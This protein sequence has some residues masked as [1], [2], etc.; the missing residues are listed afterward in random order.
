MICPV[1]QAVKLRLDKHVRVHGLTVEQFRK[2]YPDCPLFDPAYRASQS[3][4]MKAA[5]AAMAPDQLRDVQERMNVG[6]AAARA[7]KTD[8]E[9]A[10]INR[11]RG[12]WLIRRSTRLS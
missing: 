7:R 8:A 1:C 10:E 9:K 2:Q 11:R 6:R 12:G 4:A 3:K 5:Y